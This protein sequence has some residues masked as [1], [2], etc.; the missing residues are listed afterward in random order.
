M[1]TQALS[2]LEIDTAALAHNVTV[3]RRL[4]G[5]T[6]KLMVVV[7]AN[8][9]GHGMELCARAALGAGADWLAV[10]NLD[11]A[12]AL[13]RAGL[14]APLLVFGPTPAARLAEA[15]AARVDLTV[16]N[17]EAAA[18][19]V[20]ADVPGLRVHL[21]LETG[22]HRQGFLAGQLAPVAALAAHSEIVGAYSHFAD[23]EDTTDHTFAKEQLAAFAARLAELAALGVTPP[24]P[25][26]A[27]TAAALLF[28]DTYF[29]M[30]RVGIGL[31]GLWPSRE[32][33]VSVREH[34][35]GEVALRPAM[36]W[37]TRVSELKRVPAG[38][39]VGYGRT[40]K[41]TRPS[42]LAVLPV[43]YANGYDRGLSNTAHVLV[44]GQRAKLCG[45]VMMNMSV[46][47]VTAV[48]GVAI[49][50]EVVLLGA[51]GEERIGAET[52]AAWCGTINYEIVTRAE[53]HGP[54]LAV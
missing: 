16:A 23:I 10:F 14:I 46:A 13:R 37:K 12:L 52:L 9:Y 45:R 35:R 11:E 30:V 8:A 49:G 44:R 25:H 50:D 41:T 22:T 53:P 18:A 31:Y 43:G 7:K 15:A 28:P 20:A 5:S 29:Q 21:K 48:G 6:R 3:F 1:D 4:V 51:Q 27:C 36:T 34:G 47:D 38:V 32:T 24:L 42:L 39:T 17:P 40:C 33:L 19:V 26:V 2:W 54:R